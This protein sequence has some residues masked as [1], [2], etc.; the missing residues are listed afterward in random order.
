VMR[1]EAGLS[2]HVRRRPI[3]PSSRQF[4]GSTRGGAG[5]GPKAAPGEPADAP[6]PGR[7]D[8][9]EK[10]HRR[11]WRG[12]SWA[13][14]GLS[15]GASRP[16]CWTTHGV[17]PGTI[18][19]APRR[20]RRGASGSGRFSLGSKDLDVLDDCPGTRRIRAALDPQPLI[21]KLVDH[22][23]GHDVGAIP[24][25]SAHPRNPD[26]T[27]LVMDFDSTV[28]SGPLPLQEAQASK[29]ASAA[30]RT[31]PGACPYFNNLLMH[32]LRCG[33]EARAMP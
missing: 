17:R 29:A 22:R 13:Y 14:F 18:E 32:N 5:F 28:G 2:G 12:R 16:R 1:P 15:F 25:K 10:P 30:S 27:R 4:G 7:A 23:T 24:N 26:L 6:K 9:P 3:R 21:E 8:S 19:R 33:L 11:C 20:F 31:C